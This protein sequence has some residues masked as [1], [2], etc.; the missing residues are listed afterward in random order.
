M[1]VVVKK[2]A[3]QP[4]LRTPHQT[5]LHRLLYV[6]QFLDPLVLA[7]SIEVV[8]PRLSHIVIQ[9]LDTFSY[10]KSIADN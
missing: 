2:T 1:G 5:A 9:I 6:T 7:P 8:I 3:P 4:I 10:N